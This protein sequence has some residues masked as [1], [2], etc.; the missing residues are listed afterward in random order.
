MSTAAPLERVRAPDADRF[1]ND[2]A[3][4][5]RPA[6]FTDLADDWPARARWTAD[7]L[8]ERHGDAEVSVARTCDGK[9]VI[10]PRV[11]L[12]SRRMAL[13]EFVGSLHAGAPLGYLM[14]ELG[15]LP[16]SLQAE[17]TT[18]RYCVGARWQR[19]KLWWSSTGTVSSMHRDIADNLHT[20]IVGRKR[21][22]LYAPGDGARVYAASLFSSVPNS[23]RV[24]PE[25][26]DLAR[27]PRFREARAIT[28]ELHPGE[29][30]YIPGLWWH[31]VR[32]VETSVSV[33]F[34]WARGARLLLVLAADG[35]KRARGLSR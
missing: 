10:D 3:R 14:S 33:N 2:Y 6:I 18:P 16:P 32:T 15:D 25:A 28:A 35:F 19:A 9:V 24:D 34:W 13:R 1:L 30:I 26:P 21:F 23:A 17:V 7:Y 27:Y 11:G 20:Q 31:H 8:L 4:A 12:V 5:S 22:T 29:T